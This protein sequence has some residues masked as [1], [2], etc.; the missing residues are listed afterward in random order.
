MVSIPLGVAIAIASIATWI[1]WSKNPGGI[2]HDSAGTSWT[3][4]LETAISW[5]FPVL[6][7]AAIGQAIWTVASNRFRGIK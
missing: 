2:F 4:V 1:D 6:L 3:I 5:F 7:V